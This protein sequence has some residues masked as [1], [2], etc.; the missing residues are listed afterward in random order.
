[1]RNAVPK[2]F[3]DKRHQRMHQLQRS[4]VKVMNDVWRLH[5]Q[6]AGYWSRHSHRHAR[7]EATADGEDGASGAGKNTPLK[8]RV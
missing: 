4:T 7:A 6:G 8:G 3:R 2:L 1:M 5:R